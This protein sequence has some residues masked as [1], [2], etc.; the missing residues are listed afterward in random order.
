MPGDRSSN[1]QTLWQEFKDRIKEEATAAAK[2][3]MC[4]ISKR[5]AALRN[6]LKEAREAPTLDNDEPAHMNVIAL[7]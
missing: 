6:D 5:I 4:K 2:L 7:E 3:Q 1:P